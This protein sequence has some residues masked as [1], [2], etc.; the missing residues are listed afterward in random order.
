MPEARF[1]DH[2]LI[3]ALPGMISPN[4]DLVHIVA[5]PAAFDDEERARFWQRCRALGFTVLHP[6]EPGSTSSPNPYQRVVEAAD[7]E[8]L[9][10]SLPFSIWPATDDRPFHY[11][12]DASHLRKAFQSGRL[13][14]LASGNPLIS[15]GLSIGGLAA[16]VILIPPLLSTRRTASLRLLRSSWKLFLY[17]ACI[18]FAYMAIE[19]AVLLKLQAFLGKPIYGLSVGL[20]AFLLASGIGSGWT[21]RIDSE[22]IE[23]RVVLIVLGITVWGLGFALGSDALFGASIALALPF[24]I[25]IAIAPILPLALLMGMLFP[26]GMRLIA[27][28]SEDLIPWAWATNGCFSVIGIF[29]ARI[30]ALFL[31]FSRS[32]LL[33]LAAYLLVV[34]CVSIRSRSTR[35]RARPGPGR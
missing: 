10:A 22:H 23:R 16:L 27:R 1:R 18:G 14:S 13:L 2:V 4:Y 34:A 19:I 20:F 30:T 7:L 33:G 6:A 24:R 9:A 5:S 29:G 28:E 25:L 11:A 8:A 26:L 12:L 35:A 31:G 15:L 21:G 32:L 3:A 17:F